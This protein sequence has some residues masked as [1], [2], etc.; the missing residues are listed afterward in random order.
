LDQKLSPPDIIILHKKTNRYYGIEV[1]N[2]KER[3]SGGFMA[4]T[5]IPVI[6]LDTLNCRI[7][8]RCPACKKW[9]GI[10]PKV[11]SDFSNC[12]YK[13]GKIEIRCLYDCDKYS[14]D[15]KLGGKCLY[16]KYYDKLHYHYRCLV[17]KEREGVISDIISKHRIEKAK[18]FEMIEE[19]KKNLPS[20]PDSIRSKKINY[21]ITHYLWYPEL[22]KLI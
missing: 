12:Q 9:I 4:P 21:L 18:L 7:S 11:I 1:G 17:N 5:G 13:I 10:C 3:Q 14:L 8:D 15:E 20:E 16:M 6:P 22:S 19:K 2:L